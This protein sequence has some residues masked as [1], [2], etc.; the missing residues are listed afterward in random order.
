LSKR[1][2]L[3]LLPVL[4]LLA[5]CRSEAEIPSTP[6]AVSG[7]AATAVTAEP[8]PADAVATPSL[9]AE[10]TAVPTLT[11]TPAPP[12]SLTVCMAAEPESLYLYSS[13][14]AAAVAVRHAL[15]ESP[16]TELDF[17]YQPLALTEMPTLDNGGA[18]L[19]NVSVS[20]GDIVMSA[21]RQVV[22]LGP[23]IPVVNSAG[24]RVVYDGEPVEMPQLSVTYQFKPLVWSDGTPVTAEDSVFSYQ[25]ATDL[26]TP[27]IDRLADLTQSYT[28][29]SDD[30]VRWVGLPGFIDPAYMTHV[31]TPLPRHQLEGYSAAELLEAPETTQAPLSYGPF[32]VEGWTP[33]QE[34]RLVRNPYYYRAAEGLPY[35]DDL[36][37]RF[38]GT[39]ADAL[40]A[41]FESC[42]IITQDVV[43]GN[44]LPDL[45]AAEAEGL[46]TA[47]V[48]ESPVVEY[49]LYGINPTIAFEQTRPDWFED[50]RVRQAMAQCIDRQRMVDELTSGRSE[51]IHAYVP[52]AHALYPEDVRQWPYDPAAGNALLDEAGYLDNNG[53]GIREA[54]GATTPFSVTLSTNSE[55]D[56]R[57][58]IIDQIQSDLAACGL[59]VAN[60]PIPAG[61]WFAP[62]PQ[63]PVFGRRFDLA[64]FAWLGRNEPNCGLFLS[65]NIPG[66]VED[67]FGGWSNVNVTGWR[68]DE[69][70][71]ACREALS[72]LPGQP[73]Y[74]EAHQAALR[75]FAQ[76]LPALP[77]F[78]R[79]RVAATHPEVLNFRLNASQ[80]SEL[81]N[82]YE[83][84]V[85]AP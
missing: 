83:W 50:S 28:S 62:G 77:L 78:A 1:T 64:E 16:Y 79:L 84:D 18:A 43:T 60:T 44:D 21:D 34:I 30:T 75:I 80:P 59:Q 10:P 9:T 14:S 68:S 81:W 4:L 76:D 70:D 36:T 25:M 40:P 19:E 31:W 29:E 61:S 57:L 13:Y 48:T 85:P 41:A 23:G 67:G 52:T 20:A 26:N 27:A 2:W 32:E 51:V 39:A 56:V 35:L 47:H 3:I 15:Y 33:G 5:A 74:V 8:A 71:A 58:R 17:V 73:G 69:F 54:I 12:K 49:L 65:D 24:E 37:I 42:D 7:E 11:P 22:I 6:P 46:I 82:V 45:V 38:V 72:L 66:P 55:S 63:G 53:D